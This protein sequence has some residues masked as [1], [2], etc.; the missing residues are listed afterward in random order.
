MPRHG[1]RSPAAVARSTAIKV[2]VTAE[3]LSL[4]LSGYRKVSKE[5]ALALR[6]AMAEIASLHEQ[7][8]TTARQRDGSRAYAEQLEA[9]LRAAG[10][11]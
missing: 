8:E 11:M 2:E 3:H 1:P 7:L 9:R 10:L 5:A 6:R 4:A